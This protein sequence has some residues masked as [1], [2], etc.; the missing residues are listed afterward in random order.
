DD[1]TTLRSYNGAHL[2]HELVRA[3]ATRPEMLVAARELVGG[4]VYLYQTRFIYK[5]PFTGA[6]WPWHQDFRYWMAEDRIQR[7]DMVLA[8]VFLDDVSPINS[9]LMVL[10]GSQRGGMVPVASRTGATQ[11][12]DFRA[13]LGTDGEFSLSP[14][15]AGKMIEEHGCKQAVGPLG[16]V[17]FLHPNL[18]HGSYENISGS[19]RG[20]MYFVYNRVDNAPAGEGSRRPPYLCATDHRPLQVRPF[21]GRTS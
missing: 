19:P 3:W 6:G 10:P 21:P 12:G 14:E 8:A 7:P 9:P 5:A 16:S 15:I 20:L 18:V 17:L 13:N 1:G 11:K 4:D 2:N